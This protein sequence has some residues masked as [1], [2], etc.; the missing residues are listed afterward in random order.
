MSTLVSQLNGIDVAA[1]SQAADAIRNDPA[2]GMTTWTIRSRWMGGTRA[3]HHVEGCQIGDAHV[4]RCFTIKTDEP[5][6]LCGTN[7]FANPQEYL[8]AALNA[9]MMVGYAA[10]AAMMG[11]RL[12]KLEVVTTGDIDLRGFL[13]ISKDV[14]AG[15]DSLKQEVHLAGDATDEQFRQLHEMVHATSPNFY[16]LTRAI[17]T[18]SELRIDR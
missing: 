1:L 16:N 3:D 15:Y 4:K 6:E 7:Q 2:D 8:L 5:L 18:R 11:V 12:T 17:P 10:S 14:P 9:C 13:G